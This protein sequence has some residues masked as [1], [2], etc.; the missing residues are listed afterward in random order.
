MT[1]RFF[2]EVMEELRKSSLF[3]LPSVTAKNGDMEG[4]P[5]SIME[6]MTVGLPAISTRHG[7]IPELVKDGIEGYLV[8]EK[9]VSML[10]EK[11]EKVMNANNDEICKYARKKIFEE[12]NLQ[13]QIEKLERVYSILI[14][15]TK[16]VDMKKELK[17]ILCYQV[18]R[19][20]ETVKFESD[21]IYKVA[22]NS[23][24]GNGGGGHLVKGAGI[25]K[26]DL[27]K[28]ILISTEKD[29]RYYMMK[30]IEEQKSVSPV[31]IINWSII[32]EE[33][34][35]KAKKRDYKLMFGSNN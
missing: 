1:V 22:I 30:W 21:K 13:K 14:Q 5:V 15:K 26:S 16:D 33:I 24:R 29:L 20:S 23:Y 35:E 18:D 6:A 27:S 31:Q 2:L 12:F 19:K 28:R 25:P 9:D 17:K 4:I 34:V 10:K 7:G 32:P 11:I 3:V 8:D